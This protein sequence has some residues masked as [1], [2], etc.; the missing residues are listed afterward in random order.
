MKSIFALLVLC[1]VQA[2]FSEEYPLFDGRQHNGLHYPRINVIEWEKS[3]QLVFNIY[4]K[5]K[6][7]DVSGKVIKR[8]ANKVFVFAYDL[9]FRG[10]RRCRSILAPKNFKVGQ[11]LHFYFDGKDHEMDQIT[12]SS[13]PISG[14]PYPAKNYTDC[15]ELQAESQR[16]R[17]AEEKAKKVAK[18][19]EKKK[20][21][22]KP[23]ARE[24]ANL[25]SPIWYDDAPVDQR[26]YDFYGDTPEKEEKKSYLFE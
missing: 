6:P 19:T 12:V 10:E 2:S 13:R 21:E 8:G 14:V 7:I 17:V 5:G 4:S 20:L 23:I 11:R 3:T 25:N 1:L 24:P 9:I 15:S 26:A 16:K 18:N 22:K